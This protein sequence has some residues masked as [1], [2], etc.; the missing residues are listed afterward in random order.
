VRKT[1]TK[2]GMKISLISI[3]GSVFLSFVK[4]VAG[5]V[6][7]SSALVSDGANS[8]SDVVSYTVV[9]GGLAASNRKADSSHQYGHEK[10]ES[11]VSF[12]LAF[13]IF[14]TGVTIGYRGF[15]TLNSAVILPKPSLLA[16][17]AAVVSI[18]VK[19][20][21]WRIT[22]KEVHQTKLNSMRALASDHLSDIFSTAGALIGIVVSRLG[23]PMFDLI[24]SI[25]IA[26]L[27]IRSSFEVFKAS[28]HVLM[29]ASADSKTRKEL[30]AAILKNPH[31]K[32]I[33]LLRSRTSGNGYWV[34]TEICCCRNFKLH[35]AHEVAEEIHDRIERDFPYVRHLMV[36]INPCS[37][38]EE[39]CQECE[40]R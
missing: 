15:K 38:E 29:D 27:I 19:F 12:L 31:V 13:V 8:L 32:K 25:V 2:R 26:L 37:G 21:L 35:Q 14:A 9:M 36:H 30:E 28:Y 4:L 3:I 40:Q 34:E 11:I 39:F 10:I 33:D 16:L 1:Y 23:W 5:I 18:G 7:K 6:G 17:G 22:V 20:Y 24:A